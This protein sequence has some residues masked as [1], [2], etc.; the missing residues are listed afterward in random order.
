MEVRLFKK[1]A[2]HNGWT[3]LATVRSLTQWRCNVVI[4]SVLWG[5][6]DGGGAWRGFTFFL[7]LLQTTH[8]NEKRLRKMWGFFPRTLGSLSSLG[9]QA[10]KDL[11]SSSS[12]VFRIFTSLRLDTLSP[13]LVREVPHVCLISP[14]S[15]AW[16]TTLPPVSSEFSVCFLK[17]QSQIH[18]GPRLSVHW[19]HRIH[20]LA[21][22]I[23]MNF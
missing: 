5:W 1:S 11:S 3:W 22:S 8:M 21:P 12:V 6:M 7:S 23:G 20:Q 18:Q 19:Y 17:I 13:T 15:K 10:R 14:W 2:F 9:S 16:C 4:S